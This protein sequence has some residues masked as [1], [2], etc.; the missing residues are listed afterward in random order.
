MSEME[1]FRQR[2][3]MLQELQHSELACA[4]SGEFQ[5]FRTDP[6]RF[7]LTTDYANR[8]AIWKA[9]RQREGGE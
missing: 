1:L 3:D 4:L 5:Q 6:C 2:L 7:F 9:I 8:M